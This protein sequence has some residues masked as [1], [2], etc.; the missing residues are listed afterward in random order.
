MEFATIFDQMSDL[1]FVQDM[2]ETL[3]FA[4][5]SVNFYKPFRD[6]LSGAAPTQYAES[7]EQL[8]LHMYNSWCVNPI[9]TLTLCLL[10]KKYKLA[11]NLLNHLTD[12][13]DQKKLV[14]LGTLVQLIE[15][16]SFVQLRLALMKQS[17]ETKYLI[18]TLQGVLMILPQSKTFNVLKTRLECVNISSYTLPFVEEQSAAK[19]RE[20]LQEEDRQQ[21]EVASRDDA[22]IL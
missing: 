15:S 20:Q 16:P 14:Q 18:K 10:T 19:T 4:I 9:A 8:F 13:L 6:K 12:E 5:A 3:T 11:Y 1:V 2:I 17:I 22:A 7:R 21:K